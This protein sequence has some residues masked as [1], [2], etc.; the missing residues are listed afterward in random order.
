MLSMAYPMS[1]SKSAYL[2]ICYLC[3]S[4]K[5]QERIRLQIMPLMGKAAALPRRVG[6]SHQVPLSAPQVLG[7]LGRA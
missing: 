5:K 1:A 4:C 2:K 3:D 7:S 6:P